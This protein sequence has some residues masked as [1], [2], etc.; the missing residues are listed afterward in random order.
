LADVDEFIERAAEVKAMRLAK[1]KD[2]GE[3]AQKQLADLDA[4][5]TRLREVM[6]SAPSQDN[7][8]AIQREYLRMVGRD[9]QGARHEAEG[10]SRAA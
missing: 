3:Q 7:R 5:I 9:I 2:M 10:D 6:A 8:K 1:G 4:S